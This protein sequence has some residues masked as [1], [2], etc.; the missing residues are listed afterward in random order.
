MSAYDS[1]TITALQTGALILR[2]MLWIRG[3]DLSGNAETWGF[4][5]GSDNVT[6]TVVKATDPGS[7][8]SRAY[9]GGGSLLSDG[10]DPITYQL[11]IVAQTINVKLSQIHSSVQDMVR[12][13]DIRLAEAELH[14]ALFDVSTGQI[15]STPFPRFYGIIE[16]APINTPAVGGDGS[17]TLAI[18]SVSIDLTRTNPALK[19]D[20]ATKLRSGDRFR[21]YSGVTGQYTVDWGEARS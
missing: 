9:I 13:A 2:D 15:V 19:S 12:G 11:G 6:V 10:V 18:T 1:D 17:I 14:R 5:T 7:T 8:E 16:G 20:E 21:Q 4:W 3:S